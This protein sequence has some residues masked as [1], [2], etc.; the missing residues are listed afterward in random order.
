MQ[1][2]GQDVQDSTDNQIKNQ[3]LGQKFSIALIP[4]QI[5]Y[6][7][8]KPT[9]TKE[10]RTLSDPE[11]GMKLMVPSGWWLM[12]EETGSPVVED[13]RPIYGVIRKVDG[14][15]SDNFYIGRLHSRQVA[16]YLSAADE[17]NLLQWYVNFYLLD[18]G[19][20]SLN[21]LKIEKVKLGENIFVK[22][23]FEGRYYYFIYKDQEELQQF[24]TPGDISVASSLNPVIEQI[25]S[26][27]K[28]K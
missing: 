9:S 8:S 13:S 20:Y 3:D 24:F 27:L 18:S 16:Q 12:N 22:I 19:R 4:D 1:L 25:L 14:K 23:F 7:V 15:P 17:N 6:T 2:S 26:T 5:S 11:T 10:W 21:E 28:I